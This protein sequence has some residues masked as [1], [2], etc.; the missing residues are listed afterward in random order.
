[1]QIAC[2]EM[3]GEQPEDKSRDMKQ[4]GRQVVSLHIEMEVKQDVLC[5]RLSGELDH[6]SADG[7]RNQ[8]T[9]AIEQERIHHIV[10]NLENLILHGQFR[11]RCHPWPL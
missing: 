4:G 5:I 3:I 11:F 9:K 10:L 6:H 7:L 2:Q 8:V 1:M